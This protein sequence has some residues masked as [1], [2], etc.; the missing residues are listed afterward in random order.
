MHVSLIDQSNVSLINQ[1]GG[2]QRVLGTLL[3]HVPVG[4]PVQFV[5]DQWRELIEGRLIPVAPGNE[6]LGNFV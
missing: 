2:L 1:S 6:Q 3:G 4:Q 5:V